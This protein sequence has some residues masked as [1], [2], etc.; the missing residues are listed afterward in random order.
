M[1]SR[2][3]SNLKR[4]DGVGAIIT[5]LLL[6]T[7]LPLLLFVFVDMPYYNQYHRKIKDIADT[8]AASAI[9]RIEEDLL[10]SGTLNLG[11]DEARTAM[12]QTL[13]RWFYLE[14]YL[15]DSN[16]TNVYI[17]KRTNTESS[18]LD[19]DPLVIELRKNTIMSVSEDVTKSTRIEFFIHTDNTTATYT[20]TTGS[21]VQVSTPTV[22]VYIQ[23]TMHGIYFNYPMTVGKYGISEVS[24]DPYIESIN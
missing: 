23:S 12:F 18:M 1:L 14:P 20:F 7:V 9:T 19:A 3:L 6:L 8:T 10:A 22:G 5:V 2:F 16:A 21:S 24:L 13:E 15:Y 17:M 11:Y 4:K